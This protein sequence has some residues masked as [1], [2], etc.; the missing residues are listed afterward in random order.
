LK[1]LEKRLSKKELERNLR[2][3]NEMN[4]MVDMI[5]FNCMMRIDHALDDPNLLG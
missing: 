5:N 2:K 4:E 1:V 3:M